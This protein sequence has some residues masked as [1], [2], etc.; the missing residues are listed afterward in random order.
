VV[1]NHLD[2][3]PVKI[4]AGVSV[5]VYSTFVAY[6][7]ELISK[8]IQQVFAVVGLAVQGSKISLGLVVS[9]AARIDNVAFFVGCFICLRFYDHRFLPHLSAGIR[10]AEERLLP[11]G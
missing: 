8:G 4:L 9:G 5:I 6:L 3:G 11:G 1:N 10:Q 7:G 2:A